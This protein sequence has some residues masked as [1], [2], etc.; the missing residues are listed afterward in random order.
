MQG[1]KMTYVVVSFEPQYESLIDEESPEGGMFVKAKRLVLSRIARVS[2][3]R[4]A[5]LVTPA[6]SGNAPFSYEITE[7]WRF[8]SVKLAN[9]A[10]IKSGR[11]FQVLPTSRFE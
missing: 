3:F 11:D 7:A 8:T 9:S 2:G 1:D 10:G 5:F 6:Y 4:P